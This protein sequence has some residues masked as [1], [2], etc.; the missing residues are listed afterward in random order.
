MPASVVLVTG[1]SSGFGRAIAARLHARGHRVF[2]TSRR[3]SLPSSGDGAAAPVLVPMDVCDEG[4]VHAGVEFVRRH[5]GR[6]DAVVNNA[7]VG[8][9]GAIEDTTPE[10]A[11]DL[12]QTNLFGVHRVCRAVLPV[13]A[14]Q[15]AGTIV[16][17]GSIGGVIAIPFQGWYSASK[18]ALA[19]FNE[20][21]RLEVEPRGVRVVLV[22]PGDFKTGFTDNR[23]FAA[24][25]RSEA[26][27]ERCER[28]VAVMANDERN[29]G[30]PDDFAALIERIV[31]GAATRPVYR[32]GMAAQR[33]AVALKR[34]APTAAFDRIIR[35]YYG[36]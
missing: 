36:V 23:V 13:F 10:E 24:G 33:L 15:G 1:A 25:A 16:N 26:Y 19:A 27:G 28:A 7:G 12:F 21:L 18:A 6:L 30:D 29:G 9:A 3:A 14:A 11:L 34:I 2:G 32:A 5:A 8:I 20:A 31:N 22:E 4:S 17:V 35:R